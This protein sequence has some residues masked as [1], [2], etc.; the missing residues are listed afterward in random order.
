MSFEIKKIGIIVFLL[1]LTTIPLARAACPCSFSKAAAEENKTIVSVYTD[2]GLESLSTPEEKQEF[3]RSALNISGKVSVEA[4]SAESLVERGIRNP[5]NLRN[6]VS[7]AMKLPEEG[8]KEKAVNVLIRMNEAFVK[9]FSEKFL[10]RPELRGRLKEQIK[11][12]IRSLSRKERI[13][14]EISRENIKLLFEK[15]ITAEELVRRVWEN[16]L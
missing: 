5:E 15:K 3:Y 10:E 14:K 16:N 1:V 9:R 7:V 11:N 6:I 2:R 4:S 13:K 12:Y 8:Q